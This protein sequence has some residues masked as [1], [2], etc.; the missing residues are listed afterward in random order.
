MKSRW[1]SH[2]I[3]DSVDQFCSLIVRKYHIIIDRIGLLDTIGRYL[4]KNRQIRLCRISIFSIL[5]QLPKCR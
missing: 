5:E 2:I 1:R 4:L 3:K